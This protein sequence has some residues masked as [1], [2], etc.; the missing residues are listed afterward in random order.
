MTI[1]QSINKAVKK[2]DFK[3]HHSGNGSDSGGGSSV[4]SDVTC[5][6]YGKRAISRK[7]TVQRE[8]A[9]V[10]TYTRIMQMNFLN[11]LLRGLLFQIPNIL[12]QPP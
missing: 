3:I 4:K 10:G 7:T 2:V 6:K 8:M 12:Q 1:E 11:G 5:Y 9:L